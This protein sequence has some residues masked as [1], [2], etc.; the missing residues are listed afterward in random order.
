MTSSATIIL[1]CYNGARW[2]SRAIESILDQTYEN[3]ELLIIDDG[4]T[5]NSKAT[6]APH[7]RDERVRYIYQ[8]NKGFSVA[9]NNGIKASNGSLIGFIGQDDL[10][11]PNKLELQMK[12]LNKHVDVDLVFSDYYSIDPQGQILREIKASVP[13]FRTRQE[14]ITRLFLGNFIG[15]ETVLIKRKCFDEVGFFDERMTAFSDHDMWLRIIGSLNIGYFNQ[16]LVKKRE[17]DLQLSKDGLCIALRDEF[18]IVQKAIYHYPFL[19]KVESKKLF[20]LYYALG[21]ALLQKGHYQEAKKE[22]IKAIVY[23]PWQLKA[24]AAYVAPSFYAFILHHYQGFA[25]VHTSLSWV[26]G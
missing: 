12:Y 7:L 4:S 14:V 9:I 15:F 24:I 17:H 26:E 13:T 23:Q 2:V 3:F 6:I 10:W 21:I 22:L 11:M 25:Q 5:D 8:S 20:L 16:S 19:K 1:P 18:L